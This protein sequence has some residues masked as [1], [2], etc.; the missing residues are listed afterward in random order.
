MR[1][2][3]FQGF[4]E[5]GVQQIESK[6]NAWLDGPEGE[7]VRVIRSDVTATSVGPAEDRYQTAIVL[8]W[9]ERD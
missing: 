2:K 1:V 3:I 6:I 7:G 9:Y 5:H 4:A 8:V